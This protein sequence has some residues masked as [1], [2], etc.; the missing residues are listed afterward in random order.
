[1]AS[2]SAVDGSA[3]ATIPRMRAAFA[4][5]H[6]PPPFRAAGTVN[7][8]RPALDRS[9]KPSEREGWPSRSRAARARQTPRHELADA[10]ATW[11]APPRPPL[12]H[13]VAALRLP[14]LPGRLEPEQT[15]NP[16]AKSARYGSAATIRIRPTPPHVGLDPRRAVAENDDAGGEE[17]RLLYIMGDEQCGKPPSLP[18]PAE[19]SRPAWRSASANPACR[20]VPIEQQHLRIADQRRASATRCATPPESWCG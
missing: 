18:K 1:M 14:S 20:V 4:G 7:A 15:E 3:L 10:R 17:Q 9:M 12:Q 13:T 11:S 6:Q 19:S 2:R 16:P 5:A 8:R